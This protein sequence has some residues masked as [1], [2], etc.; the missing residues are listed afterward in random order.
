MANT[1]TLFISESNEEEYIEVIENTDVD[2]N[3]SVG[4]I[5]AIEGESII[6]FHTVPLHKDALKGLIQELIKYL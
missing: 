4:I 2:G 5:V 3:E 6:N 1:K